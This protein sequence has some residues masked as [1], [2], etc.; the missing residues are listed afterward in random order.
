MSTLK[1]SFQSGGGCSDQLQLE[2]AS[3]F[4][5]K[6]NRC[7]LRMRRR[8]RQAIGALS[9]EPFCRYDQYAYV[10]RYRAC[11][12]H[13]NVTQFKPCIIRLSRVV[14]FLVYGRKY[15][16]SR[17]R[18]IWHANIFATSLLFTREFF[19]RTSQIVKRS[20]VFVLSPLLA[21]AHVFVSSPLLAV[22]HVLCC[23]RSWLLR[24]LVEYSR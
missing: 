13:T 15:V 14:V 11:S 2:G 5:S 21:V 10:C 17:V 22:A 9:H 24:T 23:R 20:I 3:H 4:K 8:C 12:R 16:Y 7:W 1:A 6:L 19:L 18:T